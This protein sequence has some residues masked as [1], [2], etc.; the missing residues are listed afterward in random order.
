VV[1]GLT[2]STLLTLF[3]IPAV[4]VWVEEGIERKRA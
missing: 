1:F 3:V 2:T 4:Y